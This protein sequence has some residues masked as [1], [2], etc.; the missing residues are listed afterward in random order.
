[1][2]PLLGPEDVDLLPR[3]K[4]ARELRE[5]ILA[6]RKYQAVDMIDEG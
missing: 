2:Q 1:L 6:V 3:H 4:K 5:R